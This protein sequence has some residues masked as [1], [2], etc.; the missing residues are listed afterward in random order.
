MAVL[1]AGCGGGGD[2]CGRLQSEGMSCDRATT[3]EK[4]EAA[5]KAAKAEKVE[6]APMV[7]ALVTCLAPLKRLAC[8]SADSISVNGDEQFE[9]PRNFIDVGGY[10]VVVNDTN[11]SRYRRGLAACRECPQAAGAKDPEALGVGDRCPG[12]GGSCA[13]G[14]SCQSGICTRACTTDDDCL[15]RSDDCRLRVQFP[16]VCSGGKCTLGC[17]GDTTCK[18]SVSEASTCV[19]AACTL[20]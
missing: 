7:D 12:T 1:A 16:N 8:T 4:C 14:L 10:S 6:C 17:S 11:C 9:G 15:A 3:R 2:L 5:I 20:P 19:S 18:V 13:T